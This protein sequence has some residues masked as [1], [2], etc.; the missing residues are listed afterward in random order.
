MT[1]APFEPGH[2][3]SMTIRECV[4]NVVYKATKESMKAALQSELPKRLAEL[5]ELNGKKLDALCSA[6]PNYK[7]WENGTAPLKTRSAIALS[8]YYGI[9]LDEFLFRGP[10]QSPLISLLLRHGQN[11]TIGERVRA[12]RVLC[13]HSQNSIGYFLGMSENYLSRTERN[14]QLPSLL[15]L[16]YFC[17][18]YRISP[19]W[20]VSGGEPFRKDV[21]SVGDYECAKSLFGFVLGYLLDDMA[22]SVKRFS[23]KVG[24]TPT[25]CYGWLAGKSL[26]GSLKTYNHIF[27][28]FDVN[29]SMYSWFTFAA[30]NVSET[31]DKDKRDSAFDELRS[32]A[33][34]M[35]LRADT[36]VAPKD[37]PKPT[38]A[39]LPFDLSSALEELGLDEPLSE[40]KE[41]GEDVRSSG[42]SK[43]AA[44]RMHRE[45]PKPPQS[46]LRPVPEPAKDDAIHEPMMTRAG[47]DIINKAN[48]IVERSKPRK[49][50]GDDK[51]SEFENLLLTMILSK[52]DWRAVASSGLLPLKGEQE[53]ECFLS[54]LERLKCL[55]AN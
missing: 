13:G 19:E 15:V 26:P 12:V 24:V 6:F 23:D 39:P 31:Q 16:Y 54:A 30:T 47:Q 51:L 8:Q 36:T 3:P 17:S 44:P 27:K 45:S 29:L 40:F 25:A 48:A 10:A 18:H 1:K 32:V 43:E 49:T 41:C 28:A 55:L 38:G 42:L 33:A 52:T 7:D 37:N 9:S 46:D 2:L 4:M 34:S 5:R 53:I 21:L 11:K 35:S 20:I 22:M 50:D 14:K